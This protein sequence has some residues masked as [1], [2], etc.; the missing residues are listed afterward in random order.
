MHRFSAIVFA[1][2][3]LGS[4][5][6]A[7]S[8]R[9]IIGPS[10]P[11]EKSSLE[12]KN[13]E[14]IQVDIDPDGESGGSADADA[15]ADAVANS[16]SVQGLSKDQRY[17]QGVALSITV[18]PTNSSKW[19]V[20]KVVEDSYEKCQVQSDWINKPSEEAFEVPTEKLAEGRYFFCLRLR[21]DGDWQKS[22]DATYIPFQVFIADSQDEVASLEQQKLDLIS[23]LPGLWK[24]KC[25]VE[26]SN[27]IETWTF[28][29]TIST[30][31]HSIFSDENCQIPSRELIY[32]YDYDIGELIPNLT[33]TFEIDYTLKELK[34]K[35]RNLEGIT[36]AN[37]EAWYG[38]TDWV[39][40]EEKSILDRGF[41]PTSAP[42]TSAGKV[43]F[44]IIKVE[45]SK[46]FPPDYNTA[47]QSTENSRP[48]SVR[49]DHWL[50]R[51]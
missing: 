16:S 34:I 17:E 13:P 41:S 47:D 48:P 36:T 29:E 5:C 9:P 24:T 33:N 18:T 2:V 38:Y 3:I 23:N 32:T 28:T 26:A 6:S 50:E 44:S 27:K 42:Q 12:E 15:D 25:E 7:E 45:D 11:V 37:T 39:L 4:A 43:Y 21:V 30:I 19:V 10:S 20:Y 40:D 22:K 51:Q 14:S 31:Q 8:N 35:I 46:L 1:I 49:P